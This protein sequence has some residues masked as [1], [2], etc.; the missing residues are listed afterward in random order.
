MASFMFSFMIG[1]VVVMLFSAFK[2]QLDA[3]IFWGFIL[4]TVAIL[5]KGA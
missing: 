3:L 2:E 1:I 4:V 5:S